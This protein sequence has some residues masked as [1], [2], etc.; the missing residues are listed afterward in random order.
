MK[1]RSTSVKS[2]LH[3]RSGLALLILLLI[4][5][6]TAAV[7]IIIA[8]SA[9]QQH[10]RDA[11]MTFDKE[12]VATAHDVAAVKYLQDGGDGLTIYYYDELTHKCLDRAE[13]GTIEP[14]GRSL[15][16]QNKN[17]EKGAVGVP[18]LGD[19][20]GAQLLAV[21]VENE[22]IHSRWTGKKWTYYDYTLMDKAE[23]GTLTWDDK[24]EMDKDSVAKAISASTAQ[25]EKDNSRKLKNNEDPGIAVYDYNI[26]TDEAITDAIMTEIDG[27]AQ[28]PEPDKTSI[29]GSSLD[30][31]GY[32]LSGSETNTGA[33]IIGGSRADEYL[34][35]IPEMSAAKPGMKTPEGGIVQVW[36]H[37]ST[38]VAVWTMG[39]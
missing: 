38:K 2:K 6:V 11:K 3:D 8:V 28:I 24:R 27:A 21:V 35:L 29:T 31:K 25:Y 23:R 19:K 33:Y 32:G 18:N 34:A 26:K 7:I 14:Y 15:A 4:V 9:Y 30:I 12:T 20:G 22:V 13:I 36:I 1:K 5:A 16:A 39:S 17:A 37:G 10:L